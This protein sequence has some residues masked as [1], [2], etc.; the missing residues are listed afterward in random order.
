MGDGAGDVDRV[1]SQRTFQHFCAFIFFSRNTRIFKL[2]K[3]LQGFNL[4]NEVINLCFRKVLRYRWSGTVH[5]QGNQLTCKDLKL[6]RGK[7][8][9]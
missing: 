4:H 9:T 6:L 5:K 7:P 3:P 1:R 2:R 8:Q